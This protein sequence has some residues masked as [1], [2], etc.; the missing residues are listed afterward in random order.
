[1]NDLENWYR[2]L[3]RGLFGRKDGSRLHR[4][5]KVRVRLV[6]LVL[7]SRFF[8]HSHVAKGIYCLILESKLWPQ[9]VRLRI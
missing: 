6:D 5:V 1:M 2:N 8:F 4:A 9:K 3:S 7:R